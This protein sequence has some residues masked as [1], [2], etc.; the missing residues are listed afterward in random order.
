MDT[1]GSYVVAAR[2]GE[3]EWVSQS[4]DEGVSGNPEYALAHIVYDGWNR[5]RL[6]F[7]IEP[8]EERDTRSAEK[9]HLAPSLQD[10]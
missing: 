2:L 6:A 3:N 5:K 7:L 10:E 8:G 4:I 1:S 9:C